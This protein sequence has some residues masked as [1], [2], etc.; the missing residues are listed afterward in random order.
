MM[1]VTEGDLVKFSFHGRDMDTNEPIEPFTDSGIVEIVG[2]FGA[3]IRY[4]ADVHVWIPRAEWANIE[5][6]QA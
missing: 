4:G 3:M 2:P 5:P 6:L 1:D